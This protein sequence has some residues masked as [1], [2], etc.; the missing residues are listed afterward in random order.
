VAQVIECPT[1]DFGSGR[2]LRVMKSS[3]TL[4]SVLSGESAGDFL[5]LSLSLSLP[6]LA[7]ALSKINK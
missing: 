2:N 5:S 4:G 6:T 1:L 7:H 3:P